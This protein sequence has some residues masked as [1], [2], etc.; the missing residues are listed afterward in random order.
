M[1][2]QNSQSLVVVGISNPVSPAIRGSVVSSSLLNE[3]R[4]TLSC[5]A[6]WRLALRSAPSIMLASAAPPLLMP[7]AL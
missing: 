3:V 4:V 6:G 7:I 2:G 5:G 1:T